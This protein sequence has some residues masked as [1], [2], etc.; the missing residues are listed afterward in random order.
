MPALYTVDVAGDT[1]WTVMTTTIDTQSQ[2]RAENLISVQFV[3]F[4]LWNDFDIS[5]LFL[6][7]CET[8]RVEMKTTTAMM[9]LV[10]ALSLHI[11]T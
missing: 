8:K 11:Q 1:Q 10:Y 4:R 2:F 7:P 3:L 9:K 6:V 5:C